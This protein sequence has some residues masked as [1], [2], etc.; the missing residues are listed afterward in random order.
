M[1]HLLIELSEEIKYDDNGQQRYALKKHG[2]QSI[3]KKWS[4]N[5]KRLKVIQ[6]NNR[7]TIKHIYRKG[8]LIRSSQKK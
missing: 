7:K 8:E 6:K 2:D 3:Q 1:L 4:H 5:R